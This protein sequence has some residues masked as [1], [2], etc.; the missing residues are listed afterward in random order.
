MITAMAGG[1]AATNTGTAMAKIKTI[2]A[3]MREITRR[4][5]DSSTMGN[6]VIDPIAHSETISSRVTSAAIAGNS[7]G[8]TKASRTSRRG[9]SCGHNVSNI[10]AR[11]GWATATTMSVGTTR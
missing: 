6:S 2:V 1:D 3:A 7:N 11:L 5:E 8:K 4:G 9:G 10:A